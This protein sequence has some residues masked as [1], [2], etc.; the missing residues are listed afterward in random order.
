MGYDKFMHWLKLWFIFIAK[1][2]KQNSKNALQTEI[3]SFKGDL[4]DIMRKS[5]VSDE[6]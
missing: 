2:S 6:K 3:N 1:G 4:L 5:C